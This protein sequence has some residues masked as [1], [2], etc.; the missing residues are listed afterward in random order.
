MTADNAVTQTGGGFQS[1]KPYKFLTYLLGA[2]LVFAVSIVDDGITDQ[3]WSNT[4]LG[5][6]GAAIVWMTTNLP[7]YSKLKEV[8]AIT[9]TGA[10]FLVSYLFGDGVSNSEWVNLGILVLFTLGVI[11]VPNP[12]DSTTPT[13]SRRFMK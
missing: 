11:V 1:T 10:N 13:R 9:M 12:V 2:V 4:I 7:Q 3:E 5:V 6:A 8:S